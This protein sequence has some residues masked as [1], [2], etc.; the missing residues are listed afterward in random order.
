MNVPQPVSRW[1]RGWRAFTR[2]LGKAFNFSLGLAALGG[3]G[4]LLYH[5]IRV[6]PDLNPNVLAAIIAAL[7]AIGAAIFNQRSTQRKAIDESHR[8]KKI[9]A[10]THFFD[11]IEWMMAKQ[12]EN[13]LETI[14]PEQI[15]AE[16]AERFVKLNRGL[17][18]WGSPKVIRDFHRFKEGSMLSDFNPLYTI[19]DMFRSIRADLGN[20]N[21]GLLRGDLIA[22]Y[23][24]S[25][26]ELLKGTQAGSR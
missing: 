12:R 4:F 11:L 16:Q 9:E 21:A 24:K 3:L 7:A 23:L 5:A 19:D 17:L 14:P 2:F 20:S 8:P 13:E 15:V 18:I 10:Y 6:V 1:R 22:L 26:A 25:R